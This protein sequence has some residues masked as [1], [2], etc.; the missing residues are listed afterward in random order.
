MEAFMPGGEFVTFVIPWSPGQSGEVIQTARPMTQAVRCQAGTMETTVMEKGAEPRTLPAVETSALKTYRMR[1]S[2]TPAEGEAT[3][4]ILEPD[5]TVALDTVAPPTD[6]FQGTIPLEPGDVSVTTETREVVRHSGIEGQARLEKGGPYLLTRLSVPGGGEGDVIVDLGA[7]S[8]LL[9]REML[10]PDIKVEA[11]VAEEYGPEGVRTL[12]GSVGAFGGTVEGISRATVPSVDVGGLH[13]KEARVSVMPE[14]PGIAG[15]DVKGILG[16]DLLQRA[17]VTRIS[18]AGEGRGR[19]ELSSSPSTSQ[20]ALEVPFSMVGGLIV[21]E[22]SIEGL[23]VPLILDTGARSS[24]VSEAAARSLQLTPLPEGGDTFRGL[25]GQAV[26]TWG[27]VIPTLQLGDGSLDSLHVN[28]AE[29]AVLDRMG[30]PGGGLLG[31]NLWEYY[32][33]LEVAWE[34]EVVRFYR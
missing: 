27:A 31:Q 14:L 28:V 5:G 29:A 30:L 6:M 7:G 33:T 9:S 8:T 19:L 34:E 17:A 26:E 12:P 21:V 10:P 16:N 1:V 18:L 2:V 20:P 25:D 22:G 4:F 32:S 15:R 23:A 24:I 13:F 11:L 3:V